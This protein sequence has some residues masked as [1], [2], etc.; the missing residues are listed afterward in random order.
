MEEIVLQKERQFDLLGVR[1]H[2]LPLRGGFSTF[3]HSKSLS[4][5]AVIP[6]YNRSI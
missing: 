4:L 5:G 6:A 1:Y 2:T 3:E